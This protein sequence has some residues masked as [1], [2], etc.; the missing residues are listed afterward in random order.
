MALLFHE[1][2]LSGIPQQ[3]RRRVIEKAHW[4][5]T[6]RRAV[7]HDPLSYNLSGFCKRR[8]GKYRIIYTYDDG[9]DEMVIRFVGTRDEV[10]RNVP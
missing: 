1:D 10:Y 8:L 3:H 4:L 2:V 6:N 9:T 5:W 7:T